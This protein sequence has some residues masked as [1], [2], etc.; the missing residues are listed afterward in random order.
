M[1]A[2][3][4]WKTQVRWI[5]VDGSVYTEGK[6]KMMSEFARLPDARH[7]IAFN[8]GQKVAEQ[9][10]ELHNEWYESKGPGF[11]KKHNEWA[12]RVGSAHWER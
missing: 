8:V 7:P 6:Y 10:V 3:P 1:E 2:K 9:I 11:V 12:E 4:H 5:A